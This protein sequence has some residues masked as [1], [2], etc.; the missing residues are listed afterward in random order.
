MTPKFSEGNKSLSSLRKRWSGL[1]FLSAFLLLSGYA[2][3]VI[4]WGPSNALRWLS[5]SSIALVLLLVVLWRI[6]QDNHKI[7]GKTLFPFFGAGTNLTILRGILISFLAG[8]ILSGRPDNWMIWIPGII[9]TVA[10]ITD[11]LDGYLARIN[12]HTTRLGEKLDTTLDGWGILIGVVLAIKYGQIPWWYL[13]VG[14]ARFF[15]LGGIWFRQK[16]GLPVFELKD[17]ISRRAYAGAQM[18]M[19]SVML[20]P[21]FSPPGTYWVAT[22]FAIPFIYGFLRDWA[23]VSGFSF[24]DFFC[25]L[26]QNPS[27]YLFYKMILVKYR[28]DLIRIWI[29][30]SLRVA[31]VLLLFLLLWVIYQDISSTISRS[32][33]NGFST[34]SLVFT[35]MILFLIVGVFSMIFGVAGRISVLAVLF[36]VGIYQHIFALS[37]LSILLVISAT[38]LFFLGT[39]PGSLWLPENRLIYNRAGESREIAFRRMD[40]GETCIPDKD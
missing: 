10:V 16:L 31:T 13:S 14:L 24:S 37:P 34:E 39:G 27:N 29:P 38:T 32:G 15:F 12:N 17:R 20:L 6:L 9:F 3:L 8:F 19:I 30:L 25:K 11:Y 23:N 4:F 35:I 33:L 1:A 28:R 2:T 36:A 21:L 18:G 22:L 40:E 7:S 26:N 5:L